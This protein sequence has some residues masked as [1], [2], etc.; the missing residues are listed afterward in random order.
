MKKIIFLIF[1]FYSLPLHALNITFQN[2][3]N[4]SDKVEYPWDISL[5]R[6]LEW[7]ID[8]WNN[9][10]AKKNYQTIVLEWKL[11]QDL[12]YYQNSLIPQFGE[13]FIYMKQI[14]W[15]AKLNQLLANYKLSIYWE[16]NKCDDGNLIHPSLKE[17]K[18]SCLYENDWNLSTNTQNIVSYFVESSQKQKIKVKIFP[19]TNKQYLFYSYD[20]AENGKFPLFTLIDNSLEYYNISLKYSHKNSK[21]LFDMSSNNFQK[22]YILTKFHKNTYKLPNNIWIVREMLNTTYTLVPY[23]ETEIEVEAWWNTLVFTYESY[24]PHKEILNE[25]IIIQQ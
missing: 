18:L 24:T 9:V 15:E 7:Y 11:T 2:A 14:L 16:Q 4:D 5:T 23:Y 20:E 13:S 25:N 6:P 21:S 8:F 19:V 17:Q 12:P 3:Q 22:K 1:C 10:T